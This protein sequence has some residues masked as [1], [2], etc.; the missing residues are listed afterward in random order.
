MHFKHGVHV[1][2]LCRC[3]NPEKRF[4]NQ[5]DQ[6]YKAKHIANGQRPKPNDPHAI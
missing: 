4:P 5:H 3:R 6:L 1:P 2:G